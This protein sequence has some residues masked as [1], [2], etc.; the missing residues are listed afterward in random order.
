MHDLREQTMIVIESASPR[1][2]FD[3]A[4]MRGALERTV[5]ALT[6]ANVDL[7]VAADDPEFSLELCMA[8]W[9]RDWN[10]SGEVDD[11]DRLLFQ[12]EI[13]ADGERLPEGDPRRTPTFR[14]DVGD[15]YW[16]RAMLSFQSAAVELLLAY[17]WSELDQLLV[18][19]ASG[20]VSLVTIHL[21]HPERVARARELILAGLKHADRSRQAYLAETDDDRE[22]VPNPRQQSHPLPLPVDAALYEVWAGVLEDVERLLSGD[23]ALSVAELAQLGDHRWQDPPGGYLDI[24]AMLSRPK[25]IVLDLPALE[26]K[27]ERDMRDRRALV[28]DALAGVLGEYYVLAG[29]Q[30]PSPLIGRL[31]RMKR[32]MERGED[33][34]ERK[35]RYLLWLN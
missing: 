22:W 9:E 1:R 3:H 16:A 25:D 20:R 15:V 14:F 26:R 21:D 28:E 27:L 17:R 34:F 30:T 2:G 6:A 12:L 11:S 5:Q 35:L 4:R 29:E 10:H 7:A 13:D 32:E 18:G 33:T 8:C 19:L 23:E 31:S 24:A